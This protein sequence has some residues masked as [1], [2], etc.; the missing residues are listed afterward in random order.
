MD[1]PESVF[2]LCKQAGLFINQETCV[3]G[4]VYM[5]MNQTGGSYTSGKKL[6]EQAPQEFQSVCN[7]AVNKRESFFR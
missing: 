4:V 6:C 3:V 2:A 7:S 5:Y 1:H